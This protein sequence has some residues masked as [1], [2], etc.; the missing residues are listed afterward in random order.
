[1]RAGLHQP[2]EHPLEYFFYIHIMLAL[3]DPWHF[4][5][6][7]YG[8]MRIYDRQNAAPA[9][10]SARMDLW[11]C[12]TW[13]AFILLASGDW[14]PGVLEDLE[15]HAHF[16]VLLAIPIGFLPHVTGLMYDLAIAMTVVYA[17]YVGWCWRRGYFISGAKLALF[18]IT[19]AVMYV[20]YT[21]NAWI[22]GIAPEWTFKVG[23]AVLGIVHMTQYLAIVWRYNRSLATRPGRARAGV[24]RSFHARGTWLTAAVYVAVCLA[25]GSTITTVHEG[26]WLM[27]ALLAIGFTS[28]LMHY[29][30]DGFIWKV[31]HSEN[32]ENLSLERESTPAVSWWGAKS[33]TSRAHV[34]L[35]QLL[36]F[37]VPA[38]VLTVGAASIWSRDTISYIDHMYNAYALDRD[39]RPG[40]AGHEARLAF[41]AMQRQL[42]VARKLAEVQPTAARD[43]ALAYL[44]FNHA[45]YE[46]LVIPSLTGERSSAERQTL[47]FEGVEQAI[48]VMERALTRSGPLH[49]QGREQLSADEARRTLAGWQAT[50]RQLQTQRLQAE[51]RAT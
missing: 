6:Q 12:L 32:R 49:H 18:T 37:G 13:F 17:G 39:G 31:R 1:V 35:R 34:F 20:A 9:R 14:L 44:I 16:G 19:F 27:S 43:A 38:A 21:P 30:F 11:L 42:P 48:F 10:L 47:F 45:S 29:Y 36:F 40:D 2:Q 50:A 46:Q 24:F 51:G 15:R 41:E 8:F 33:A 7:H 4:L 28:T 3:W 26:R 22:L 25:Y 5:R 23:F